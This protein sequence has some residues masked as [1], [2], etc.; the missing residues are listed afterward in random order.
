M[1]LF[2]AREGGALCR[3]AEV[4]E[5]YVK[6]EVLPGRNGG[7]PS[8]YSMPKGD[9]DALFGKLWRPAKPEDLAEDDGYQPPASI[10]DDWA[11]NPLT[12]GAPPE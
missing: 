2:V 11:E 7:L 3:V 1:R 10:P 9:Y 4:N 12:P 6:I 8:S 5:T